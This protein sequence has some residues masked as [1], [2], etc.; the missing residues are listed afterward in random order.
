MGDSNE[1]NRDVLSSNSEGENQS[2]DEGKSK[3]TE[4]ETEYRQ[5]SVV[6]LNEFQRSR[7]KSKIKMPLKDKIIMG[8]L[9]KYQTYSK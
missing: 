7:T 5:S 9:D 1:N 4:R 3:I 6:T 2:P 8:P